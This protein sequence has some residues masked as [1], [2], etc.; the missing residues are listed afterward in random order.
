[1][2]TNF[3]LG[4]MI[5]I[6]AVLFDFD[7][8]L[9]IDKTGSTS[10]TNYLSN[11]CGIPLEDVKACYYKYN[12]QLLLGETTHLEIWQDFCKS[13]GHN[14]D[15]DILIDSFRATRLDEKMITLVKELKEKYFVGMITENKSDRISTI[16]EYRGL[17]EYFDVIAISANLHS[18]KDSDSIFKYVLDVLDISASECLFIDNTEKNLIIPRK[19]GMATIF[20]DDDNR[21]YDLFVNDLETIIL[22][23]R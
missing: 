7:G 13:L 17:E 21:D 9:T 19:M 5:M 22:K 10:I 6:K 2:I 11:I 20:Y 18:G 4:E 15:Y 1:M 23:L 14:I 12:K 3:V 8:V 16:L